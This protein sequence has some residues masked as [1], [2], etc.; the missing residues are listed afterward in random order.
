MIQELI[1]KLINILNI[2]SEYD[3]ESDENN[4]III[5]IKLNDDVTF[6]NENDL[7]EFN[8]LQKQEQIQLKMKMIIIIFLKVHLNPLIV[9]KIFKK[10]FS[11]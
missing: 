11:I 4:K 9:K 1:I 2:E 7:E 8:E 3:F 6:G 10:F 5:Y